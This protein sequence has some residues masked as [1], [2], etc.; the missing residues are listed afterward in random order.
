M[1]IFPFYVS[2]PHAP[3]HSCYFQILSC[4][5]LL[6]LSFSPSSMPTGDVTIVVTVVDFLC[7]VASLIAPRPLRFSSS[8]TDKDALCVSTSLA[9]NSNLNGMSCALRVLHNNRPVKLGTDAEHYKLQNSCKKPKQ[10]MW[11][12]VLRLVI[13]Q[14]SNGHRPTSKSQVGETTSLDRATDRLIHSM[15][16]D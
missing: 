16:D 10:T 3:F 15:P 2:S 11:L 12:D 14:N 8:A 6:S 4:L 13:F 5:K 1:R 9:S 7:A